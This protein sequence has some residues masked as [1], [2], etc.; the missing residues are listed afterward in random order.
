MKFSYDNK[1]IEAKKIVLK[2][3]YNSANAFFPKYEAI[4][5]VI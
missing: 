2:D 1:N 4:N 5:S 3:L